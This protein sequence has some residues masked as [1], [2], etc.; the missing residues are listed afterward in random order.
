MFQILT[1]L[2]QSVTPEQNVETPRCTALYDFAIGDKNEK[3]CLPFHKVRDKELFELG[4][5]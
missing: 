3:D 1:A 4:G 5:K 2:P